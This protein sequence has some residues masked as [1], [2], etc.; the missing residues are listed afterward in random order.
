MND[1]GSLSKKMP[2]NIF[3]FVNINKTNIIISSDGIN[4][5]VILVDKRA[6]LKYII[7]V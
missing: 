4:K 7:L 2:Q 6:L 1:V 5:Q 3:L